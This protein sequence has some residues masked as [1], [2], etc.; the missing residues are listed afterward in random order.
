[1]ASWQRQMWIL[2]AGVLLCSSSYTMVIPLLP[3]FLPEL[4]VSDSS[5]YW[6]AGVVQSSAFLVGAVMAPLWGAMADKYGKRKMI[7][8]AGLSLAVVYAMISLVHNPWELVGI[9]LLHGLVG[10]FVPASMAIVASIAP[11]ERL[12]W[13]LGTMQ[14]ASM[15]GGIM[16]PLIGGLLS[17]AFGQ[18]LSFVVAGS[19]IL[20][21]TLAVVF[22]VSEGKAPPKEVAA[23]TPKKTARSDYWSVLHNRQLLNLLLL[24]LLFQLSYNMVQPLLTLHIADLQGGVQD[25]AA[26]AG[27]VLSLVGIAGI[28]ASPQWGKLGEQRGHL[29]VL[30][31]CLIASGCVI[32]LQYF[33]HSLWLFTVVQFVFGLFLA[34]IVPVVNTLV[35]RSTDQTFR[36]RSFGLTTSANQTGSLLGPLIGGGLGKFVGIEWLFVMTGTLLVAAGATVALRS[37]TERTASVQSNSER[38]AQ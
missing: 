7:I 16:G 11:E 18:R 9:R 20:L 24:L 27:F 6:W 3:L 15:S 21:A 14:A 26:T 28:L 23:S 17:N 10:G 13:S 34:G 35:V 19:F 1:M 2:W 36:G 37:F 25:V 4:G 38:T 12:G 22:F 29:R 5:L 8:R 33:V 31:V 32:S 30:I